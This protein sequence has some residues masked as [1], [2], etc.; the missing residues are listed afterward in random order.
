M[1]I[2]NLL[3]RSTLTALR[4]SEKK[5]G[6]IAPDR[7]TP[8]RGEGIRNAETTQEAD[9]EVV[10]VRLLL[11]GRLL[12]FWRTA[13]PTLLDARRF[14]LVFIGTERAIDLDVV[15]AGRNSFDVL[16]RL[17]GDVQLFRT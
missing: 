7:L 15:V 12:G 17:V 5:Q 6:V 11:H 16:F 9:C 4:I 3:L 14:E 1:A 2:E 13:S 10:L 8:G